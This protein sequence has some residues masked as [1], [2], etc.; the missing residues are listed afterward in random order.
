MPGENTGVSVPIELSASALSDA[1]LFAARSTV[2]LYTN[3]VP[4]SARH[5]I[6]TTFTPIT[7]VYSATDL[8]PG[9]TIGLISSV[10]AAALITTVRFPISTVCATCVTCTYS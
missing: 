7:V 6:E 3:T 5:L 4:F 8:P 9:S 1:V 2:I 10:V